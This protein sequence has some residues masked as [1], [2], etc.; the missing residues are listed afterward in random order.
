MEFHSWSCC[1]NFWKN[2]FS[3]RILLLM[4]LKVE[5]TVASKSWLIMHKVIKP[6]N[7]IQV[8]VF[9]RGCI[10]TYSDHRRSL[11]NL[12]GMQHVS[13]W[14]T[15]MLKLQKSTLIKYKL[16]CWHFQFHLFYNHAEKLFTSNLKLVW[17]ALS[18]CNENRL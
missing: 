8:E 2:V 5:W 18:I 14:K 13:F 1:L 12:N 3:V 17:T 11:W 15:F 16:I 9:M 10:W 6:V 7:V 4:Q